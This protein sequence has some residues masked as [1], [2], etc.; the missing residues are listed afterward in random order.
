[1]VIAT[2]CTHAQAPRARLVGEVLALAG[3][4]GLMAAG[5]IAK[6]SDAD[7]HELAVASSG[8][9]IVG[10]ATF[11]I[12]DLTDEPAGPSAATKHRWAKTWIERAQVAARGGNCERVASI[13]PRVRRLDPKLYELVF[14]RDPEIARC[15]MPDGD[16]ENLR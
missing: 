8:I 14:M 6:W 7:P 15:R 16:P 12:G 10:I 3:V 11:A 5:A 9:S 2:S 1:M 13:E 4:A